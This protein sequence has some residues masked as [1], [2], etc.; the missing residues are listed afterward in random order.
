MINGVP[1][2]L[3]DYCFSGAGRG[4]SADDLVIDDRDTVASVG[5]YHGCVGIHSCILLLKQ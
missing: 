3:Y 4:I 1:A 5:L 2:P